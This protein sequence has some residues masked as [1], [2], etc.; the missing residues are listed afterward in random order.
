[1]AKKSKKNDSFVLTTND[2]SQTK[3]VGKPAAPAAPEN[4]EGGKDE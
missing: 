3:I 4:K 2:A 1:M